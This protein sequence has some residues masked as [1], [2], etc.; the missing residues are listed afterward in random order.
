MRPTMQSRGRER[1]RR[2]TLASCTQ[3]MR[4]P[5]RPPCDLMIS[6]KRSSRMLTTT[7]APRTRSAHERELGRFACAACV[8]DTRAPHSRS[9]HEPDADLAQASAPAPATRVAVDQSLETSRL[10]PRSPRH[11]RR[12]D[13]ADVLLQSAPRLRLHVALP[14]LGLPF[15]LDRRHGR[16]E[17]RSCTSGLPRIRGARASSGLEAA[18]RPCSGCRRRHGAPP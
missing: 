1:C 17:L 9:E 5:S 15:G 8:S 18:A 7:A 6:R 4:A 13:L 16:A 11:S 3:E 2:L 14:P 10:P 12:T